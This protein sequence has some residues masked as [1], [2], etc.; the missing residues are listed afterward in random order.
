MTK[1]EQ[2]KHYWIK[3]R[4]GGW[5]IGQYVVLQEPD[6]LD[7]Q[8]EG[9]LIIGSLITIS[10]HLPLEIRGPIELDGHYRIR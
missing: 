5:T 10:P 3:D 7:V 9:F 8:V 4:E 1:L 6:A 2:S